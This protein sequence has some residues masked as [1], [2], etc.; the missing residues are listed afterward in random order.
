[1]P[2]KVGATDGTMTQVLEGNLAA[3]TY[4]ATDIVR[5]K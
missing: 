2:V 1:V 3:G 4:V 5:Q